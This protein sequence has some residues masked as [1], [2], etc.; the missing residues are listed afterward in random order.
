MKRISR[1]FFV[2]NILEHTPEQ[3]T[4]H[5]SSYQQ[6]GLGMPY[7]HDETATNQ[8]IVQSKL[9]NT[10][11]LT[12]LTCLITH[13]SEIIFGALTTHVFPKTGFLNVQKI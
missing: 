7:T 9:N 8:R 5:I 1:F 3:M 13:L 2:L 10:L 4:V 11:S 12:H 6:I